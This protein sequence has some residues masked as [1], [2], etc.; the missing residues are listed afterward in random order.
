[1]GIA[2][3][4]RPNHFNNV[5]QV[6]GAPDEYEHAGKLCLSLGYERDEEGLDLVLV[7]FVDTAGVATGE[8]GLIHPH[9]LFPT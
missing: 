8:Q 3:A 5:W 4:T 1:M 7:D 2:Q 6:G 9:M